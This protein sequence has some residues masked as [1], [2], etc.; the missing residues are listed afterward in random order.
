MLL[1]S[2]CPVEAVTND[3]AGCP[4]GA[5]DFADK[6]DDCRGVPG[7]NR[8]LDSHDGL[9]SRASSAGAD[10][11][12]IP[13]LLQDFSPSGRAA[14]PHPYEHAAK[15]PHSSHLHGL[16]GLQ[17]CNP[18]PRDETEDKCPGVRIHGRRKG[19][20][21]IPRLPVVACPL[22]SGRLSDT[23]HICSASGC[24]A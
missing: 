5:S 20:H 4:A 12:I 9:I 17:I 16:H 2:G 23:T 7:D 22:V 19:C 3:L 24:R 1:K 14:C 10:I 18:H 21:R 13:A 6:S 11:D 8:L 15:C